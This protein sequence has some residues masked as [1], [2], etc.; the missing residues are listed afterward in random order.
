M[1][2]YLIIFPWIMCLIVNMPF[3]L[4]RV[5]TSLRFKLFKIISSVSIFR[6]NVVVLIVWKMLLQVMR[7]LV[8]IY[9]LSKHISNCNTAFIWFSEGILQERMS[10]SGRMVSW[11]I[12]WVSPWTNMFMISGRRYFRYFFF[13]ASSA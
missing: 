10:E 5:I 9:Y 1:R 13:S 11:S 7:D 12:V 4:E 3:S 8:I 6:I 2:Y